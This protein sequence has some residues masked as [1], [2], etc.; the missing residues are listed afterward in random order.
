MT[1]RTTITTHSRE[2]ILIHAPT[3]AAN[4]PANP[5]ANLAANSAANSAANPAANS[6]A[7]SA[8]SW[9]EQ[10]AARTPLATPEQAAAL[11][12]IKTRVIYRWIEGGLLHFTETSEEKLLICVNSLGVELPT[13][14]AARSGLKLATAGRMCEPDAVTLPD[15]A[16][17]VD[18]TTPRDALY[19]NEDPTLE[20][21][22]VPVST[23]RLSAALS[24]AERQ[25][26]DVLIISL[27]GRFD[28]QA[29]ARFEQRFLGLINAGARQLAFDC[30]AL[31][32]ISSAGLRSFLNVAHRLTTVGSRITLYALNEAVAQAFRATGFAAMFRIF[33]AEEEAILGLAIT[34][35]LPRLLPREE[36]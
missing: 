19:G 9:C 21:V 1:R 33:A 18:D 3:P 20:I 6:A 16:E 31:D 12:G 2:L 17:P 8:E 26:D 28:H 35:L 22:P 25:M 23:M 14:D 32:F 13:A 30:A 36:R 24:C 34:G 27:H 5:A 7:N 4:R 29:T 10:C 15:E 11:T